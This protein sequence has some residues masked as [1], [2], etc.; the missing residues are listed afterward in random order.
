[1]DSRKF[2]FIF[3]AAAA[4]LMQHAQELSELD[5]QTGDGDHGFSISRIAKTIIAESEKPPRERIQDYFDDLCIELLKLNGGSAGNL[6][7][8]MMEG[9]GSALFPPP[10]DLAETVCCM[11]QGA[12]SGLAEISSAK[13]GEK[14]L[15][16][17]LAAALSAARQTSA[18]DDCEYLQAVSDAARAG[19]DATAHMAAHYGRAKNLP[20]GGIGYQD[21]GA[22]SLS[23]FIESLCRA[24]IEDLEHEKIY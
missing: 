24:K 18:A 19:A 12:L 2:Q 8:V 9:I 20:D 7:G 5:A 3:A 4:R 21:P 6:W 16:D 23:I 17:T 22:V 10:A 15:L 11:L 1:M 13:P 14:T